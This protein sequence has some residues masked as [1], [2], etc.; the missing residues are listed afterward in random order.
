MGRL[1]V[2]TRELEE[3][4]MEEEDTVV[5]DQ[6]NCGIALFVTSY[7]QHDKRRFHLVTVEVG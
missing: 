6:A 2:F 7:Q 5:V 4:F 3:C 1:L